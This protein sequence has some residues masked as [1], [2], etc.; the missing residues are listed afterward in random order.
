MDYLE[1][2]EEM[3]KT[4]NAIANK[5]IKEAEED[6]KDKAYVDNFLNYL[7]NGSS[8][9]DIA[10]G[11]GELLE[12]YND[13]GFIA[14]GID[15]SKE[16]VDISKSRVPNANV[17]N[18]NLYNLDKLEEKFDAISATFILV[19]IPKEKIDEVI[20]KISER[21]NRDGIFF[22][23]FTTSLKEG[24]QEEPLDSNYKYYA[25]N[26]SKEEIYSILTN[27]GFEILESIEATRI[28]KS[29]VAIVIAKKN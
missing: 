16:M 13:K 18:M 11:T 23:V 21:L 4:Y 7:K 20:N 12:Y 28:N 3:T 1:I 27:N 8:I 22:T 10:C 29:D 24:I 6:W 9:L 25:V 5:Y 14:T 19:H 15:I 17:I 2:E 26:Y